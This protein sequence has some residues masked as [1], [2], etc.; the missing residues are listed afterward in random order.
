MNISSITYS[1]YENEK[2][3]SECEFTK[4]KEEILGK[5]VISCDYEMNRKMKVVGKRFTNL[6][7]HSHFYTNGKT[8]LIHVENEL[9]IFFTTDYSIVFEN[10]NL[11]D[12]KI[13]THYETHDSFEYDPMYA[14]SLSLS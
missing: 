7:C 6:I 12:G 1:V 2:S 3:L 11:Q 4:I 13:Y 9:D 5:Y 10:M 14:Y 8:F